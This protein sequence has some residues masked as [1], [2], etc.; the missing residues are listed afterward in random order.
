MSIRRNPK[1][2]VRYSVNLETDVFGLSQLFIILENIRKN[3]AATDAYNTIIY[4]Q[5][6]LSSFQS[7]YLM[8]Y[9]HGYLFASD[10]LL[11]FVLSFVSI[12]IT[13]FLTEN[14]FPYTFWLPVKTTVPLLTIVVR[15][16]D[17]LTAK[18]Y[19]QKFFIY[20]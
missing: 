17:I 5:E 1:R 12:S 8:F 16:R 4:R 18:S 15:L 20:I 14:K 6:K 13:F 19:K 11:R 2:I 3:A 10:S 9:F 7:P